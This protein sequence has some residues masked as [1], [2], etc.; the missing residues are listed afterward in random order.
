MEFDYVRTH[1]VTFDSI[2]TWTEWGLILTDE[3]TPPPEQI[4]NFIEVPGKVDR[5]LDVTRDVTDA[6]QFG[7][8]TCEWTFEFVVRSPLEYKKIL[9][10]ISEKITGR[11][12]IYPSYESGWHYI[13]YV[14]VSEESLNGHHATIKVKADCSPYLLKDD[15]TEL[16]YDVTSEL[17][18]TFESGI[19]PVVVTAS[20]DAS[21]TIEDT[22]NDASINITSTEPDSF[23]DPDNRNWHLHITGTGHVVFTF[24]EGRL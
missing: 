15:I 7:R 12:T 8:R 14:S 17:N 10:D 22:D 18:V 19:M 16:H 2:N 24:R 13:G 3:S 5:Y 9:R 21:F 4:T 23:N 20:G 6:I 11:K 1:S